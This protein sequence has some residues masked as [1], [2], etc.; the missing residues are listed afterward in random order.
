MENIVLL[1]TQARLILG[2][3]SKLLRVQ[4]GFIVPTRRANKNALWESFAPTSANKL[5]RP[6]IKVQRMVSPSQ[7]EWR[8]LHA[9]AGSIVRMRQRQQFAL[10]GRI[11]NRR[12]A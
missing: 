1:W 7:V 2:V 6:T 11:A 3:E 5:P 10:L 9:Q 8:R 12:E 4:V